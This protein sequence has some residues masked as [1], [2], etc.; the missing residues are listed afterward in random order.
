M[1]KYYNLE[2]PTGDSLTTKKISTIPKP[3]ETFIFQYDNK[4][5]IIKLDYFINKVLS[6]RISKI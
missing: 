5:N 6:K 3:A 4:G 1:V 2:I